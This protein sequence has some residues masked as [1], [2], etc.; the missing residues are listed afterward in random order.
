MIRFLFLI[1]TFGFIIQCTGTAL[2][3]KKSVIKTEQCPDDN[4]ESKETSKE[5]IKND[6]DKLFLSTYFGSFFFEV[7][8]VI[9][10]CNQYYPPGFYNKPFLPPRP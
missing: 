7:C 3:L 9:P 8:Y 6:Q 10:D 4:K 5:E 2:F 1:L